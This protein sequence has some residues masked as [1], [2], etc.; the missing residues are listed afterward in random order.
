MPNQTNQRWVRH[1]INYR[2]W[3]DHVQVGDI[4]RA[5]RSLRVVRAVGHYQDGPKKGLLRSVTFTIRHCSWTGR[6]TTVLTYTDLFHRGFKPTGKRLKL[7]SKIDQLIA[8]DAGD[9]HERNLACCDVK[10]V[11]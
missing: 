5:G 7:S 4:L 3:M 10:G 2:P 6:C 11:P 8:R 1:S 9:K